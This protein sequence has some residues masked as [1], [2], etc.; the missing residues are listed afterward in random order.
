MP[1]DV[2]PSHRL[3]RRLRRGRTSGRAVD[4]GHPMRSGRGRRRAVA[5]PGSDSD[6]IPENAGTLPSDAPPSRRLGRCLPKSPHEGQ[7]HRSRSPVVFRSPPPRRRPPGRSTRCPS[8]GAG[9][10]PSDVPPSRRLDR[11]LQRRRTSGGPSR[12][13]YAKYR[14]R[15]RDGARPADDVDAGRARGRDPIAAAAAVA[16]APLPAPYPVPT[17]FPRTRGRVVRRLAA[18]SAGSGLLGADAGASG[19]ASG[20]EKDRLRP[21]SCFGASKERSRW[22]R[23]RNKNPCDAVHRRGRIGA[24]RGVYGLAYSTSCT[25]SMPSLP[26]LMVPLMRLN[27]CAYIA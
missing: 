26:K 17:S 18:A 27:H 4:A 13:S 15:R 23:V 2:P 22:R 1:F 24:K 7:G 19:G 3:D 6:V 5:R 8:Q 11:H 14:R 20:R 9:F 25:K 16:A 21:P 10:Q 12:H